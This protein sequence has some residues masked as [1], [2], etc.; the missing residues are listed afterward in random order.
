MHLIDEVV[1]YA[2]ANS[3]AATNPDERQTW[4][5]HHR[6][7]LL[8]QAEQQRLRAALIK[9]ITMQDVRLCAGEGKLRAHDVLNGAN[10]VLHMRA[11]QQHKV[12]DYIADYSPLTEAELTQPTGAEELLANSKPLGDQ[13]TGAD[14]K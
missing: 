3:E 2:K 6:N 5:A 4:A 12:G 10:A 11:N 7:C 1:G 8:I 14:S 9:P 13:Q